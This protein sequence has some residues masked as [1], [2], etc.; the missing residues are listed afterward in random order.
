[1]QTPLP[2]VAERAR[3][4]IALRLIPFLFVL[5]IIAFLDRVNV[6]YA[7]LQM[8]RDLGFTDSIL[9]F[10]GG[11]F[12][13]GYFLL[14]VPGSLIVERWSARKWIARIMV[15]W[16]IC[17]VIMGF[18]SSP[19][20]FYWLRFLLGAAEAGFFPGII[21]Y[22]SHW[23]RY[24]DRGKAIALF[25]S[26]LPISN[27]I[28]SPISG[29]ILDR[30]NWWGMAGWRWV[31][32]LEGIPAVIFGII[33]LFYLTD[34]PHE[35]RWLPEDERQ[36]LVGE[37]HREKLERKA[38]RALGILDAFRQ[39]EVL[40]MVGG[41]FL[42]VAGFYGFTLW[43][44]TILQRLSGLSDLTVTMVAIIPY[45]IGLAA[46]IAVGWSSDRTG[47][48][49]WHT[50]LPI[51]AAAAGMALG[52]AAGDRL[53]LLVACFCLVAAGVHAFL[54]SFWAMPTAFLT[55]SAA[56]ATIGLVNSFGNLGGFAGPYAVGYVREAT[57]S[58]SG[59]MALL[60]I[61]LILGGFF[62]LSIKPQMKSGGAEA[63]SAGA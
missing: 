57:S 48:R 31:F 12:F 25:M 33:T 24:E 7:A 4:R 60:T 27:L 53:W 18:I 10:G 2:A 35:A 43:L 14:E 49:R 3:R 58:F 34:W 29:L 61:S 40:F 59:G 47:E 45:A 38:A 23:F 28:G 52:I 19:T 56:A 13:V 21:V 15:S 5:Y 54:P 1:M 20:Q 17:A 50:A 26:A 62:M 22:L 16:G 30:I 36:W 6:S 32:I 42:A 39:R 11:I 51:F 41:Y 37:L 44:P 9:G 55:E 46:M 63:R 8:R